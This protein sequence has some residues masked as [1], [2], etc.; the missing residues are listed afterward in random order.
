[1][2][3]KRYTGDG[4]ISTAECFHHVI[5][6][7]ESP[8]LLTRGV[9]LQPDFTADSVAS[10]VRSIEHQRNQAITNSFPAML[11]RVAI[12][13]NAPATLRSLA[14]TSEGRRLLSTQALLAAHHSSSYQVRAHK[15]STTR[16]G[17]EKYRRKSEPNDFAA[18]LAEAI[19]KGSKRS[20]EMENH[21]KNMEHTFKAAG[22]GGVLPI[23]KVLA[24]IVAVLIYSAGA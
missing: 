12:Y 20:K 6:S 8:F 4:V 1:V 7:T 11:S 9:R 15:F 5:H 10:K 21:I 22:V 23:A 2:V 14:L 3:A 13:C 16:P 18:K 24:F 17:F 19:K